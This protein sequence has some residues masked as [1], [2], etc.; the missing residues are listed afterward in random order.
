MS[1]SHTL[2][3]PTTTSYLPTS[4]TR[5]DDL[6]DFGQLFYACG[7]NEFTQISNILRQFL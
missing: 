7:N 1:A 5:L 6:L 4:V 3:N 2:L